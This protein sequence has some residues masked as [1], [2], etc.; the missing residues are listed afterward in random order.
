MTVTVDEREGYRQPSRDFSLC[1]CSNQSVAA[2]TNVKTSALS[3]TM[4]FDNVSPKKKKK[5]PIIETLRV[6]VKKFKSSFVS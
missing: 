4:K 1:K 2:Q 6:T 5:L 3:E